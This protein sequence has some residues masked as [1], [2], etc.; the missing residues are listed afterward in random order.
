MLSRRRSPTTAASR[1]HDAAAD[2]TTV[3]SRSGAAATPRHLQ[4]TAK[5]SPPPPFCC[6]SSVLLIDGQCAALHPRQ[7]LYL[8][9]GYWPLP[10]SALWCAMLHMVNHD[11]SCD[12]S[13]MMVHVIVTFI[14][15][16]HFTKPNGF[17]CRYPHYWRKVDIWWINLRHLINHNG[18]LCRYPHYWSKVDIWWINYL[19]TRRN[20]KDIFYPPLSIYIDEKI[21]FIHNLSIFDVAKIFDLSIF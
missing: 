2:P 7:R 14:W 1:S 9:F 19:S 13:C 4:R 21:W 6:C 16:T 8:H 17:L 18:F 15:C 20:I 3:V 5:H 11:D 12:G 10:L